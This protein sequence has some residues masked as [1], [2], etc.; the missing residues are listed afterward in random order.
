MPFTLVPALATEFLRAPYG[1]DAQA[2]GALFVPLTLGAI[3]AAAATPLLARK[4]GMVGVL[5]LGVIANSLALLALMLSVVLPHQAAYGLLL[6]D[7]TALGLGF[8]LNFSAVNELASTLL[9]RAT[10]SVTIANVLTGLGTAIT[11]LFVGGLAAGGLWPIWPAIL[12][13]SP[14][15][16]ALTS[17]L[18]GGFRRI[19]RLPQG[20][21][22]PPGCHATEGRQ[23]EP[24]DHPQHERTDSCVESRASSCSMPTRSAST[25]FTMARRRAARRASVASPICVTTWAMT[26]KKRRITSPAQELERLD[27]YWARVSARLGALRRIISR[28]E[29]RP[30][31]TSSS[32]VAARGARRRH[33]A[34]LEQLGNNPVTRFERQMSYPVTRQP[35]WWLIGKAR[36][37]L[38]LPRALGLCGATRSARGVEWNFLLWRYV[39]GHCV[40]VSATSDRR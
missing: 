27:R 38:P 1:I 9:T 21:E 7:R 24:S 12:V 29:V 13:A 17:R 18:H 8:G 15:R 2:F 35:R 6:A 36:K 31:S 30:G 3:V 23:T 37:M 33:L 39:M 32:A 10:R 22:F 26:S 20:A 5:R 4:R 40:S 14:L 28:R 16:I 19:G 34:R 25:W 11:P